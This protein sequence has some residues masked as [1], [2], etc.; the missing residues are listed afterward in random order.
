MEDRKIEASASISCAKFAKKVQPMECTAITQ[1]GFKPG[2]N[3]IGGAILL[4][5]IE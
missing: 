5:H 4:T 3:N 2:F 1:T